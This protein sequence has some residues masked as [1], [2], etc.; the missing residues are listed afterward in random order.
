[1]QFTVSL[2]YI[3]AG[4]T[5]LA[6]LPSSIL[7]LIRPNKNTF[8]Y[9]LANISFAFFMFSYQVHEKTIL[10]PLLPV[11]LLVAEI[12]SVSR[13][14]STIS[15]FRYH[16]LLPPS[17]F[18]LPSC[19]LLLFTFVLTNIYVSMFPLLVKDEL[20]LPYWT[21]AGFF[22]YFSN[23]F[24]PWLASSSSSFSPSTS[25][26]ASSSA[27]SWFNNSRLFFSFEVLSLLGCVSLHI[28]EGLYLPPE[29]FPDLFVLLFTTYSFLN[30]FLGYL[31]TLYL[32]FTLA[33][34]S[35]SLQK[36]KKTK[37]K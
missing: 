6:I 31:I 4:V 15:L 11:S 36:K 2:H 19:V 24:H 33:F 18:L 17:S 28:L 3:R 25:A 16:F 23:Y 30:F 20:Q 14:Q 9:S 27:H 12:P 10:L 29:R 7:L 22:V 26:S 37:T 32:Q 5:L 34:P 13:W 1:L 8:L 35:S 21:L